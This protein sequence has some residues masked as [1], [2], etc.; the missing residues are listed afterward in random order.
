M[1][2]NTYILIKKKKRKSADVFYQRYGKQLLGYAIKN[3]QS[4]SYRIDE[5]IAWDLIY[6]TFYSIIDNIDKYSF[7]SEQKFAAFVYRSFLNNLRN[8]FRD[9][10]KRQ[11][12]TNDN[13]DLEAFPNPDSKSSENDSEQLQ[14]LKAE[15][16]K[17]E[18]WQRILL[19]LRAQKM[20]YS[21]IAKYVNKPQEQLKVY[22]ARL[23][24]KLSSNMLKEK[25]VHNG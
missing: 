11:I 22:Y 23:K 17:L 3:W 16:A 8:Y 18:D 7:D 2:K 4:E 10:K 12:N 21:E 6:K 14:E 13:H 25:E 5:D 9:N 15:L 24:Q 20:P 19:L 1:Q